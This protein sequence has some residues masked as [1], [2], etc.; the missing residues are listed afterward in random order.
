MGRNV[1]DKE[2]VKKKIVTVMASILV[3]LSSSDMTH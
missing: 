3:E 2:V 1:P